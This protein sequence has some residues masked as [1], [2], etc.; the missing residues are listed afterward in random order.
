MM[1]FG[2][3]AWYRCQGGRV[4]TVVNI[5]SLTVAKRELVTFLSYV[6]VP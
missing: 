2:E 6:Q 4:L 5:L 3:I 1:L